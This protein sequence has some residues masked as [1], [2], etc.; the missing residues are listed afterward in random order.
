MT[1]TTTTTTTQRDN[2]GTWHGLRTTVT[3]LLTEKGKT[4]EEVEALT[5]TIVEPVRRYAETIDELRKTY[6]RIAKAAERVIE[7]IDAG[8]ATYS[9]DALGSDRDRLVQ[10]HTDAENHR[11]Q[12]ATMRW[13]LAALEITIDPFEYTGSR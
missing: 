2:L 11:N 4:Q 1:T 10:L 6:L 5:H 13:L 8:Y 9:N 12:I 7:T 3:Y